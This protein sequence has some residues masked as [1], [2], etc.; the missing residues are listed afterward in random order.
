MKERKPFTRE[1]A[2]RYRAAQSTVEESTM[3][4]DFISAA[5]Y[6]RKY[7]IGILGGE[8]KI[9]LL[10]LNGKPVKAHITRKTR[11]KRAYK[12]RYGPDTAA[13]VVRLG[14]FFR[15]MCGRRLVPLIRANI[16]VLA[17][18]PRFGITQGIR[19]Q[20]IQISRSTVERILKEARKK[21]RLKGRSTTKPGSLLKHQIPVKVFWPWDEQTPGFCEIDTG[22]HDGGAA[23]GE[24]ADLRSDYT[25]TVT[26]SATQ[27][28]MWL[29]YYL[30]NI[31]STIWIKQ[32]NF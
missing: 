23:S 27:R 28:K 24:F 6:N 14:D 4:D 19:R 22:S 10:C 11:R 21:H 32:Y 13:C 1:F 7:A 20:L 25:L 15:G 5:G 18:E 30:V 31:K 26:D 9:K 29:A 3:L 8:G 16:A 12:K 2:A 17:R